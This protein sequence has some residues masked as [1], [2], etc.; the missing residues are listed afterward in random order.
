MTIFK[1]KI[2]MIINDFRSYISGLPDKGER[3]GPGDNKNR[4]IKCHFR[5]KIND[6][7]QIYHCDLKT[8]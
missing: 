8:C 5:C 3:L 2:E 6:S 7:L 4:I 1:A